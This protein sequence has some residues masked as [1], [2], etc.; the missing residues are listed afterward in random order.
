MLEQ[1]FNLPY[2]VKLYL[3][4]T[5][6]GSKPAPA[7]KIAA[8]VQD[9]QK[10]FSALFGGTTTFTASGSWILQ[11]GELVT[12]N[13]TI[14]QSF[15]DREVLESNIEKV[16]EIAKQ[17]CVQFSQEAVSLEINNKLYFIS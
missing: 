8:A 13:I 15:C 10:K 12:E 9:V 17:I 4:S 16:L 5:T 3:P 7:K 11:S 2:N 14:V 6:D 1:L